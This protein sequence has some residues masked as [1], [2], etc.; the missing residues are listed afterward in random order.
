MSNEKKEEISNAQMNVIVK[1]N[2]KYKVKSVLTIIV[3]VLLII[4]IIIFMGTIIPEVFVF[5]IFIL[6]MSLPII[7]LLRQKIYNMVPVFMK[8]SLLE[9]DKSEEGK[10]EVINVSK[11]Y[12]KVLALVFTFLLFL[13]SLNY[14]NKFNKQIAEKKSITKFLGSFVCIVIS[15]IT[16]L[17]L[18]NI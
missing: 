17:E 11:K 2:P 4:G 5:I 18:E 8:N 7:I 1:E 14:L 12:K 13:G 9:I 10:T 3:L 15:G 16:M 6:I